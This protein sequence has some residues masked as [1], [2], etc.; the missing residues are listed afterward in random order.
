MKT[1]TTV[2]KCLTFDILVEEVH[3]VD[4]HGGQLWYLAAVYVR[5]GDGRRHFVRKSRLPGTVD[6]IK[7]LV[8][9]D[10]MRVFDQLRASMRSDMQ[11]PRA[12]N[13]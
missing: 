1:T 7:L 4:A 10:G 8:K 2:L 3:H 6:E 12:L 13:R 5:D 9:R 11:Q